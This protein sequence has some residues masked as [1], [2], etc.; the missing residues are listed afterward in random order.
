M[1]GEL[2]C[3]NCGSPLNP[4]NRYCENCGAYIVP[5]D[6]QISCKVCGTKITGNFCPNCGANIMVFEEDKKKFR[7]KKR[8]SIIPRILEGIVKTISSLLD[9]ILGV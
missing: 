4:G 6:A 7:G 5:A 3:S 2:Q 1:S 9:A 8:G